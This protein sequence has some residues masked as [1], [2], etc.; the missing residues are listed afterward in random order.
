MFSIDEQLKDLLDADS[1]EHF[2]IG[3]YTALAAAAEKA[4]LSQVA[5]LCRR[6]IPEEENM[7]Q[8]IRENL[9][10]EVEAYLFGEEPVSR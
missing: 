3:C 1:M 8:R 2:E 4:G 6:I 7:A 10:M 9:P 5:Q